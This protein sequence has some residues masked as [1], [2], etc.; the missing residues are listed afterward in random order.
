MRY[1]LTKWDYYKAYLLHIKPRRVY[2]ILGIL[3]ICAV[4]LVGVFCIFRPEDKYGV[5]FGVMLISWIGFSLFFIYLFPVY[6]LHKSYKQTRGIGNEIE[7]SVS[8]GSFSIS[9]ENSNIT[10]PY[11]DIF[12]VKSN[13]Y[14]FL[15]YANQYSYH[16]I[17]KRNNDLVVA[18]GTIEGR[19][20]LVNQCVPANKQAE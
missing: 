19:F 8:E 17:P 14:Y 10:I 2:A 3:L 11:R 9:T 15:V 12:K 5:K 13:N 18:A 20:R 16:I 1:K 7:I 4:I 6:P